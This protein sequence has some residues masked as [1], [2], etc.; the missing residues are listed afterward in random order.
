MKAKLP[1]LVV[2]FLLTSLLVAA[3]NPTYRA[4]FYNV[5]NLFDTHNDPLTNDDEFTP[6]GLRRWTRGRYYRK[7]N[8]IA[9]AISYI[10]EWESPF[11]VGLCEV[12]NNLVVDDLVLHS[13]LRKMQYRYVMT[14]S[15]DPRG[16]DV[17]LLYQRD[18]FRYLSHECIPVFL[19]EAPL[20][21]T[22]DILHV[23]GLVQ[24][25][26]TLDVYVCHFPSR[27]GSSSATKVDRRDAALQ[28]K[29]SVD[30]LLCQRPYAHVLLMGDFNDEPS[31]KNLK[32][33]LSAKAIPLRI[34]PDELYNVFLPSDRKSG[35]YKYQDRWFLFD[36]I[37]VSGSL[38]HRESSFQVL[39]LSATVCDSGSL[40]IDDRTNGGQRPWKTHHGYT[41]EGGYSDHLP[42]YVDF[43]LGVR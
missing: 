4:V 43:I 33:V 36:Q 16:I 18:R 14:D 26:D 32:E 2:A 20:K 35:S 6:E 1:L 25:G 34:R 29:Q 42:V 13:P 31:D 30:T 27:R 17:A 40:K 39:P 37:I 22:R 11:L 7:I 15:P 38:L 41:Y 24:T 12:E 8:R 5:E 23:T 19:S 10:G 21:R 3:D 28:L 9:Q